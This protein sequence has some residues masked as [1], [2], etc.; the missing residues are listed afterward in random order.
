MLPRL[1]LP[2]ALTIRTVNRPKLESVESTQDAKSLTPAQSPTVPVRDAAHTLAQM[3][4][5]VP[6]R[7]SALKVARALVL[8]HLA[9]H[10]PSSTT[11]SPT[12]DAPTSEPVVLVL[13]PHGA[14]LLSMLL[15]ITLSVQEITS[16]V[17]H[18]LQLA[19][20]V[21]NTQA[22]KRPLFAKPPL[23]LEMAAKPATVLPLP[24]VRTL[25][26]VSLPAIRSIA[27]VTSA[28]SITALPALLTP[29]VCNQTHAP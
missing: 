1:I 8:L 15:A 23:A 22:V 9:A 12:L 10:S 2:H 13:P 24:I 21:V 29:S 17:D 19:Q 4:L 20:P 25:A 7:N 27:R 14:Q 16:A 28:K 11:V 5:P 3:H 6:T 18:L 26:D